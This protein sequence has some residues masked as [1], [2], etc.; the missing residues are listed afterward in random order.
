MNEIR[1][2]FW[3][4]SFGVDNDGNK[5]MRVDH[6]RIVLMLYVKLLLIIA[7]IVIIA[8]IISNL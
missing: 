8:G 1:W 6:W 5:Y 3:N 4:P 7:A 2:S